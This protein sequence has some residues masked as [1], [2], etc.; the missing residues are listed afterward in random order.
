MN[1]CGAI[2]AAAVVLAGCG[3]G[4]EPV[5]EGETLRV[6]AKQHQPREES[7]SMV[8]TA[9]TLIGKVMSCT[10]YTEVKDVDDEDW[11]V[12]VVCRDGRERWVYTTR[13]RWESVEA[14]GSMTIA[15]GDSTD[16]G[17]VPT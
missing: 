13:E 5:T 9:W 15:G 3:G 16:D 6:V 4:G 17:K 7:S 12:R 1:R 10:V 14:G 2:L 11:R 8:C